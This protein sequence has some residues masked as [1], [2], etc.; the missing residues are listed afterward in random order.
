MDRVLGIIPAR[1]G[2]KRLDHKNLRI[3]NGK[4]LVRYA[5]EAAMASQVL[6]KI[7]LS[8]D[9]DEIL[10]EAL[11]YGG[12]VHLIKRP[13][14]LAQDHSLAI[15]YVK[16]SV[17]FLK[18]ESFSSICIIQPTSPLTLGKDIDECFQIFKSSGA[19]SAV[20]VREVQFDLHPAKFKKMES[21]ILKPYFEEEDNRMAYQELTKVYVRNGALY[22]SSMEQIQTGQ[23]L[24]DPCA[25]YLMPQERSVDINTALDLEFAEFLL[26]KNLNK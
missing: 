18:P 8:S 4:S 2:S 14:E 7:V 11:V 1:S 19:R 9:A 15:E 12:D 17:E 13:L 21:G 25:A 22:I 10:S 3:I 5:I 23:L 24:G 26:N 20:S 16:H 6:S